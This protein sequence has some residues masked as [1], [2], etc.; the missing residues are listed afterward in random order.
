MTD[1]EKIDLA[2]IGRRL[3]ME[4]GCDGIPLTDDMR[5]RLDALKRQ[6]QTQLS[7]GARSK[8]DKGRE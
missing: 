7:S 5:Q 2:S 6:E 1:K 3:Q 4:F 8:S